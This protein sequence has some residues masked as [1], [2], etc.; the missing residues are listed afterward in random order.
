MT[1]GGSAV[2]LTAPIV[3][4]SNLTIL[5]DKTY[6]LNINAPL[7][8]HVISFL[9]KYKNINNNAV[10][11]DNSPIDGIMPFISLYVGDTS[12]ASVQVVQSVKTNFV[13]S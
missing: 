3:S 8:E 7:F 11:G 13:D 5:S 6:S 9:T 1:P 4:T 10:T 12:G 2:A